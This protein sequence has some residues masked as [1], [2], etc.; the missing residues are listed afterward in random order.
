MS[1]TIILF[2]FSFSLRITSGHII[3][4]IINIRKNKKPKRKNPH[5]NM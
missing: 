4:N 2:D 3:G 1:K 5:Q